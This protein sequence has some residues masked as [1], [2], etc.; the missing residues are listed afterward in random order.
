VLEVIRSLI[1]G[2]PD[3]RIDYLQICHQ[4]TLQEQAQIDHDSV[5]LLAV[6]IGKTRL[7]DNSFLL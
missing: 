5:L 2:M 3:A 4:G 7:I 1:A 6:F